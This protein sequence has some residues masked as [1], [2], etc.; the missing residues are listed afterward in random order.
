MVSYRASRKHCFLLVGGTN[1][2]ASVPLVVSG[3]V[4]RSQMPVTATVSKRRRASEAATTAIAPRAKRS[5]DPSG[6]KLTHP[7]VFCE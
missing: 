2:T 5:A 4:V 1:V 7:A 3:S 6:L